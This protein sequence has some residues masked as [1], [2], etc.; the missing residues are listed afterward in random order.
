MSFT[1]FT[2]QTWSNPDRP[3]WHICRS[4]QGVLER[5]AGRHPV[6]SPMESVVLDVHGIFDCNIHPFSFVHG[7]KHQ[8]KPFELYFKKPSRTPRPCR[9]HARSAPPT[10]SRTADSQKA[11]RP[12]RMARRVACRKPEGRGFPK[13]KWRAPLLPQVA[14]YTLEETHM[15]PENK[16]VVEEH[17]L[18]KVHFQDQY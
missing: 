16:R 8:V 3:D 4:G 13:Q 5:R 12:S 14:M 10:G 15:E 17:S 18:P 6:T 7:L 9:P 2:E 11:S 1:A